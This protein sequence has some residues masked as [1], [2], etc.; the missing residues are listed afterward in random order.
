MSRYQP[1][2]KHTEN[3][4]V[5]RVGHRAEPVPE[6]IDEWL[7][8]PN[9]TGV[10]AD[11]A[12][13]LLGLE[14][15][16]ITLA[17]TLVAKV[18]QAERDVAAARVEVEVAEAD[19]GWRARSRRR[20]AKAALD[21]VIT[22]H[23]ATA[24]TLEDARVLIEVLREYVVQLE[25]TDGPLHE[26]V[27]GWSRSPAVPASVV[28]FDDEEHFVVVDPRRERDTRLGFLGI[29]N[30]TFGT[31]WRRDGDDEP[32]GGPSSTSGTWTVAY[33]PRTGE[34]YA[35]RRG[36]SNPAQVW[37]LGSGFDDVE[38]AH[39]LLSDLEP[40]MR[41]PNSLILVAERVHAARPLD[42]S[43]ELHFLPPPTHEDQTTSARPVRPAE[44][45]DHGHE[46]PAQGSAPDDESGV[47]GLPSVTVRTS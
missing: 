38:Q 20:A 24:E 18:G 2:W 12:E 21:A 30:D 43:G 17:T 25:P 9:G 4:L 27:L 23:T 14:G 22:E 39:A 8:G 6:P 36:F 42:A 35:S 16:L 28:V 15:K 44:H 45:V 47:L 5:L 11:A 32:A 10:T 19:R 13:D 33:I 40:A 34:I 7:I 41:Q 1:V 31:G 29:V 46:P 37:L 26:A 3:G